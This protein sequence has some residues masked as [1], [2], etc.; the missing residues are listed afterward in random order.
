M[1][2]PFIWYEATQSH[3]RVLRHTMLN[4][5][6][7]AVLPGFSKSHRKDYVPCA[8]KVGPLVLETWDDAETVI[9]NSSGSKGENESEVETDSFIRRYFWDD[10]IASGVLDVVLDTQF[11]KE[12]Y[13]KSRNNESQLIHCLHPQRNHFNPLYNVRKAP[14]LLH[15]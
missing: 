2:T 14:P 4:M 1:D 8:D 6:S 10:G 5:D 3:L 7:I 13:I 11:G 9:Q 12:E 15:N